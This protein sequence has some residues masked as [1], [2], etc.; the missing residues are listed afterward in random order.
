MSKYY[1]SG[2]F[3]YIRH[4]YGE[5]LVGGYHRDVDPSPIVTLP[6]TGELPPGVDLRLYLNPGVDHS[7]TATC[8]V[9]A[10]AS[11]AEYLAKRHQQEE[12]T[13]SRWFLYYNARSLGGNLQE[14][15]GISFAQGFQ[16][17]Q[18]QGI[19]ETALWQDYP[20]VIDEKPPITA[21][22]E[23]YPF[24]WELPQKIS[25]DLG[26][27][28]QA[29]TLGYPVAF[30]LELFESFGDITEDG[31]VSVPELA[32]E[33]HL[34]GHALLAVG[35][36]DIDEVVIARNGW[37]INWGDRGYCYLPYEYF[38]HPEIL[39]DVW[40]LRQHQDLPPSQDHWLSGDSLFYQDDYLEELDLDLPNLDLSNDNEPDLLGGLDEEDY[41][42][43][44]DLEAIDSQ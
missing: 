1:Q 9:E 34:G 27:L 11:A 18:N 23:I 15:T 8:S 43:E 14:D 5:K 38:N 28:K 6:P 12:I 7:A 25:P 24:T 41:L 20:A 32:R 3:T 16:A 42:S 29:L 44:V 4:S 21:Y 22:Q 2:K 35:Y 40:L 17:L 31:I 33:Y 36:S 13:L 19:C 37:G 26:S 30:G 39:G 10:I